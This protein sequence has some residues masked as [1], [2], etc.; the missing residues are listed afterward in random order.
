MTCMILFKNR[1]KMFGRQGSINYGMDLLS[2]VIKNADI[3]HVQREVW[4]GV[5]QVD[6]VVWYCVD[7]MVH[8][9]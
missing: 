8:E 3:M 5:G 2:D 9:T 4:W 7:E 6:T 1:M